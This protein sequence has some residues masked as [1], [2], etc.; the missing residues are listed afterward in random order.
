MEY[1]IISDMCV[2]DEIEGFYILLDPEN[3]ID[4]RG[5][6]FMNGKL[7]DR[8]GT[9]PIKIWD[10]EGPFRQE[11]SGTIVKVRGR[12]S[13]FKSTLQLT[14]SRIRERRPDDAVDLSQLVSVAPIDTQRA[15][16]EIR[17]LIAS[18]EDPDYRA[19]CEL[20]WEEHVQ[21]FPVIPAAKSVHHSFVSGLLMHTL[22]MLRT[23]DFLAGLYADTIDRSLLL[24]GTFAHDLAKDREFDISPL[25]LVQSYSMPGR[26]LGHLVMGAQDAADA[27]GRAGIPGEKAVLLQ[28]MILS[29]HG[30]PEFGAAV[31]PMIPEAE[32]LSCIDLIDSRMEI[33]R[34]QLRD[35]PPGGFSGQI[36][37]LDRHIYRQSGWREA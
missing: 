20:L 14:V 2:G 36:F 26:L 33:Y 12:V 32:L 9:I 23:A 35:V 4:S 19:V 30:T 6:P 31:V 11:D 1:K 28:H 18:L 22:Y 17:A 8:S 24:A 10:F 3:K 13:E 25:G 7:S 16:D 27:C 5:K 29:H 15:A 37:A 34:E 21:T